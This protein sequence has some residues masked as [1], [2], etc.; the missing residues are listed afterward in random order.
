MRA[1][2]HRRGR[3][4]AILLSLCFLTMTPAVAQLHLAHDG[5]D[6]EMDQSQ[7]DPPQTDPSKMDHLGM[8]NSKMDHSK[9]GK[10]PAPPDRAK[11]PPEKARKLDKGAHRMPAHNMSRHK[12]ADTKRKGRVPSG[13]AMPGMEHGGH[14]MAGMAHG[15]MKGFLG[16][17]PMT[18]EGSG[19][20]WVPDATPHEGLHQQLA[21]WSVMTHGN[22]NLIYDNQGGLRGGNK[23]FVSGM[24]M[25][26]AQRQLGEGTIGV[27]AMLSPEPFMGA[28][29]YPLLLATGET[30]NGRNH[31][32]DRQ[33]PHELFM[34][35]AAT[36]SQN[37]TKNSSV[38]IYGGLPGEPALG[39][40]AF[41]H[42]TSGMDNPEAP[43][44]HHWLDSTHITFGVLTA[45]V[46]VNDWKFEASTFRGRE[47]DQYRYDIERPYLDSF[48]GR[49]SWNPIQELS[50]QV[51]Y[52]RLNSPEQLAPSMNENRL[53]A[54][55]IYTKL[56]GDGHLWSTTAAWG[57]KMLRPGETLDAFLIES[58]VI[59]KNNVTLFMRA[60]RADENELTHDI[61]GLDGRTFTVSKVSVGGIYDFV[62][63][64]RVKFGLGGLVSRYGIPGD[65]VN[66]YGRDPTSYMVF[67]RL[68]ML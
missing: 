12:T 54:S 7:G 29:G 31:L 21:E 15:A 52:G 10:P 41:M 20:S 64:E 49:V 65:L 42:R 27:R 61:P 18:R 24:L 43:I 62:R 26:M 63:T 47:P 39:P 59:L 53:T 11:A 25:T 66:E 35:L 37:I 46:V 51:S 2:S 40:P 34:E 32:V 19:T 17:Y 38:F 28:N 6:D 13:G 9:M 58:S 33:H 4:C 56:F 48:S 50:L 60:E 16:P 3:G 5:H 1:P 36:Y 57:R 8:D 14:E 22:I 67:G 68:K 45:G 30:A 44:S 55:A 23:T